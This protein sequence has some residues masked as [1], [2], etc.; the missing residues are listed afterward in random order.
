MGDGAQQVQSPDI[1]GRD[2]QN[3]FADDRRR[4]EIPRLGQ[5]N[6][7]VDVG[8]RVARLAGAFMGLILSL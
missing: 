6:A 1:A 3:L 8:D 5:G 7:P 2:R 4:R